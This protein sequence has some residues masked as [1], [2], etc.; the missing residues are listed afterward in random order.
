MSN[1]S[2]KIST[3][4]SP[5][6][7]ESE[8]K[9]VSF[10][11]VGFAVLFAALFL[12]SGAVAAD[13]T[14]TYP[15]LVI[16]DIKGLTLE[17][18]TEDVY[19]TYWSSASTKE[20][21]E[22]V[23]SV[24]DSKTVGL[25]YSSGSDSQSVWLVPYAEG[26]V[27]L[28]AELADN[29]D[30]Y[31]E[32]TVPVSKAQVSSVSISAPDQIS[33]G[34][35]AG[36]WAYAYDQYGNSL[37]NEQFEWTVSANLTL[38]T[39]TNNRNHAIINP[40]S[41]GSCI[42]TV[43]TMTSPQKIATCN[44]L[45]MP[46]IISGVGSPSYL[47]LQKSNN[48]TLNSADGD[49]W[50]H[51]CDESGNWIHG[52]TI[53]WSSSNEN[54]AV[55][56][57]SPDET[58]PTEH[59]MITPKG[60]GITE[61]TA[62]A[63]VGGNVF[64]KSFVLAVEET[65]PSKISSSIPKYLS[66]FS[67][68]SLYS[69][70]ILDQFGN[71][72]QNTDTSYELSGT[73]VDIH[74]YKSYYWWHDTAK[75]YTTCLEITPKSIG[76]AEITIR[77]G[78]LTETETV[79]V[80]ET[81]PT[82]IQINNE[83]LGI[84]TSS[85]HYIYAYIYD[86]FGART[87]LRVNWISSESS[88]L[89]TEK[90]GDNGVR[91]LPHAVGAVTLTASPEDLNYYQIAKHLSFTIEESAVTSIYLDG[92]SGISLSDSRYSAWANVRDQFGNH[93]DGE[94]IQ[95]CVS[96]SSVLQISETE[97]ES[98]YSISLIPQHTG[99]VTVTA[100]S[101]SNPAISE[102]LVVTVAQPIISGVEVYG[103][104]GISSEGRGN[105]W[106]QTVDQFGHS[107]DSHE[108]FTISVDKPDLLSIPTT[109]KAGEDIE[110]VPVETISKRETVTITVTGTVGTG[111]CEIIV[112][113]AEL[114]LSLSGKTKIST[115][116]TGW[117]NVHVTDQFGYRIESDAEFTISVGDPSLVTLSA[118]KV[119]A[120][121]R[122]DIKPVDALSEAKTVKL[123]VTGNMVEE[124]VDLTIA[125]AK[126]CIDIY[127]VSQLVVSGK[128]RIHVEVT[129]QFG[130]PATSN[131]LISLSVD[132]PELLELYSDITVAGMS[133]IVEPK[134][135]GT[136]VITAKLRSD[137]S[138][139]GSVTVEIQNPE[140]SYSIS[141][142]KRVALGDIG[143]VT[144][145][146]ENQFGYSIE[147][148][149]YFTLTVSDDNIL[150]L[151]ESTI[152]ANSGVDIVPLSVG[153]A[154]ITAVSTENPSVKISTTVTV[155]EKSS[156]S[157]LYVNGMW[158]EITTEGET[159]LWIDM[160]EGDTA[161]LSVTPTGIVELSTYSV[162]SNEDIVITPLSV[163]TAEITVSSSSRLT[164]T[165]D[166]I[167]K[168][169]VL[170]ARIS[171]NDRLSTGVDRNARIVICDQFGQYVPSDNEFTISVDNTNILSVSPT[172]VKA[173]TEFVIT[174][175]SVGTATITV[176]DGT[177]TDSLMVTVTDSVLIGIDAFGDSVVRLGS[178]GYGEVFVYDQNNNNLPDEKVTIT[179][180]NPEILSC[181]QEMNTDTEYIELTLTPLKEGT[182]TVTVTSV[183][184]QAVKN[185][186][187]VRVEAAAP[188]AI[189][190]VFTPSDK[191][192]A[193]SCTVEITSETDG[194]T[195]YYTTDGSNPTTSS[196][197][198]KYENPLT[199]TETTV[200]KAV[201]VKE[202]MDISSVSTAYYTKDNPGESF[203]I[204]IKDCVNGK[205]TVDKETANGDEL[206]TL[207]FTPD[208]GYK[209]AKWAVIGTTSEKVTEFSADITKFAMWRE[210]VRIEA[211]FIEE[212]QKSVPDTI[213]ITNNP[214]KLYVEDTGALKA[215]VY[216]QSKQRMDTDVVWTS[217]NPEVLTINAETGQYIAVSEGVVTVTVT[218]GDATA[219]HQFHVYAQP[220][221]RIV[222]TV[223]HPEIATYGKISDAFIVDA[224]NTH[225]LNWEWG[226]GSETITRT[227]LPLVGLS[228]VETRDYVFH[229]FVETGTLTVTLVPS[230]IYKEGT[231]KTYTI[232]VEYAA[233]ENLVITDGPASVMAGTTHT[234]T[235][236]ATG[237][238]TFTWY[239]DDVVVSGQTGSTASITFPTTDTAKTSTVKVTASKE[240]KTSAPVT[241]TVQISVP[242]GELG[243]F[244][245][246][247]TV[248][249]ASPTVNELAVFNID[250]VTNAVKYL[251]SF[252]DGSKVETDAPSVSYTLKDT[253]TNKVTV[254]VYNSAGL[255][256]SKDFTFTSAGKKPAKSTI[257]ADKESAHAGDTTAFAAQNAE[258]VTSWKW[259]L[260]WVEVPEETSS[261]FNKAWTVD[262]VG[263]HLITV[264]ATNVHG[265]ST[266][267]IVY[268]VLPKEGTP[269]VIGGI[270]GPDRIKLGTNQHTFNAKITC[271]DEYS[272]IWY[273]NG[274]E[275][276][277]ED[278]QDK[279]KTTFN[280]VGLY[281]LKVEVTTEYG[282]TSY[283]EK[284]I[285]VYE[286]GNDA[287]KEKA[288]SSP[289]NGQNIQLTE[290]TSSNGG[291]GIIDG[292][293][294]DSEDIDSESGNVAVTV[295][296]INP[297]DL[298]GLTSDMGTK[299]SLLMSLEINPKG[300]KNEK[301]LQS[302]A[303]LTFRLLK[304]DISD[305][306]AVAFFRFD[307]GSEINQWVRLSIDGE[308]KEDGD[309]WV[310]TVKTN[311]MSQFVA[312]NSGSEGLVEDSEIETL[313]DDTPTTVTPSDGP[314]KDTGSGNYNE[315][316]R[317]V[318]NG[319][320][321]SFGTSKIV[322]SVDLPKGLSGEVKLIA[323]SET[324]GPEGKETYNVFEINI[325]NYPKGE[326]AVIRFTISAA[327]LEAKGFGPAD[328]RLYHY[329][330]ENG[331]TPLSTSYKVTNDG[332]SYESETDSFS[333]FAIV[334]EKGA[335]TERVDAEVP[336]DI[337]GVTPGDDEPL[338]SIPD[339]PT[340]TPQTPS[341]VFG[342][343]AGL[344]GAGLLLRRK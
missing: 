3:R 177:Y 65:V 133:V 262:D 23:W 241:K 315:Y 20:D 142:S 13:E 281:T 292:V 129:D 194:A 145:W 97:T 55:I 86:Q 79:S 81:I 5:P 109:A 169:A 171:C 296:R 254:T 290:D 119:N 24:S 112:E 235:A 57:V 233:P 207:T 118:T 54:V 229:T 236:F 22:V 111:T 328:I 58:Y 333:P 146:A 32:C 185:K 252:S 228:N 60:V 138:V 105:I 46:E 10:G 242:G 190:P 160:P 307:T 123:T 329:D 33:I 90:N 122:V 218:S 314:S 297:E 255:S 148:D 264:T 278:K 126:L 341:P 181:T 70:G 78:D 49:A 288:K 170:E 206:V 151:H 308:P 295:E 137:S 316:P 183:S 121:D 116:G 338:P 173:G 250:A 184:N 88:I 98:G 221:P 187:T 268:N 287:K 100:S 4:N 131:E 17:A 168:E 64:S 69:V 321:V 223:Q 343:I 224:Q 299:N 196:N 74:P 12:F 201:A 231:A 213:E 202:G 143:H 84:S 34:S 342:V 286:N 164:E 125:P 73:A 238:D 25:E 273:I 41:P 219:N 217:L 267:S 249:P 179:V 21:A 15:K 50:A 247:L 306:N 2:P 8:R 301:D 214:T 208:A 240:G 128:D 263:Q 96:D 226:D 136:A 303:H 165:V 317:T 48:L 220:E 159:Y 155:T 266:A 114:A 108:E 93:I 130:Y 66:E 62:S 149:E 304:S 277:S 68:E 225:Y 216:D 83:P 199:I 157:Y 120:G 330:E 256:K 141:A 284:V 140:I 63:N 210:N 311:G 82:S 30:V 35:T 270:T 115:V 7:R 28:R 180:D 272:V 47:T 327:E 334:F 232:I 99:T 53:S 275:V 147:S 158:R 285:E 91:L 71:I 40:V 175:K 340:E 344:L 261:T 31:A 106:I 302:S 139:S 294:V 246:S 76:T 1:V 113:P 172:T 188:A 36:V 103:S 227:D 258:S 331:W 230:N 282:M 135:A 26:E 39:D 192:F 335:A 134:G 186:F 209:T 300:L 305:V 29:P 59:V 310:F 325:P 198:N 336:E 257:T 80:V 269:A 124:T 95:W 322:K 204:L 166:V 313:P 197:I 237:A 102:N 42:I 44:I 107:I 276:T 319:G 234:Y 174:P 45:V 337:P 6:L 75:Y 298:K 52:T 293:V 132:R 260:D 339:T 94:M 312:S 144:V 200:L 253:E 176:F 117:V 215:A 16:S 239:L 193:E 259:S 279:L 161:E 104:G 244:G 92:P 67:V 19:A 251:W 211:L 37:N 178:I 38:T 110:I 212:E 89:T 222:D 191:V 326:K 318:T 11:K 154:T 309:F 189:P 162:S 205:V 182:A 203:Q 85:N 280:K 56:S 283:L 265:S 43:K 77:Y 87:T 163:G 9:F 324:P 72:I 127:G 271:D 323:K 289:E 195:I 51:L 27:T 61:I 320:E 156:E 243:A 101:V 274:E 153:T 291:L 18:G 152:R 150:Q 248:N 167:V 14:D 332:V 245:D